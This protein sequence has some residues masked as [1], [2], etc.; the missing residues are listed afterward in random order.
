ML[1][2]LDS[3]YHNTETKE[4][5]FLGSKEPKVADHKLE[6]DMNFA[7][8]IKIQLPF[9]GISLIS[10]SPQVNLLCFT[11]LMFL[12]TYDLSKVC[13]LYLCL[14]DRNCCLLLPRR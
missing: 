2:V 1:S 13:L 7:E 9:I 11:I 5:N 6:L 4:K 10:S 8:V 14:F 12:I 3:N